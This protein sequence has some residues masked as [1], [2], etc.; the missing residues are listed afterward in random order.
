MALLTPDLG[1]I[2]WHFMIFLLVLFVLGRYAW[3]P[4]LAFIEAREQAYEE[5]VATIKKAES[6]LEEVAD[7]KAA[8]IAD[9]HAESKG[10]VENAITQKTAIIK[11]AK[12]EGM[13]EKEQ[14]VAHALQV[15]E[16]EKKSAQSALKKQTVAL[17]IQTTE[18]LIRQ[19]LVPSPAQEKLIQ[20]MIS[21]V[22]K[23]DQKS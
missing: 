22:E 1:F 21:E 8:I 15:I 9:A 17:V 23:N 5:A 19:E 18:K 13:K 12:A 20:E 2:F 3:K 14:I 11:A 6:T 10:I 4:I 7:K 16:L